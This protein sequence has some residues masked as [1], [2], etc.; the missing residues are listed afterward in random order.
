LA[1]AH[2]FLTLLTKNYKRVFEL[3]EVIIRNIVSFFHPR[4]SKNDIFDDVIITSTLHSKYN[5][6]YISKFRKQILHVFNITYLR[7]NACQNCKI[8]FC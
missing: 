4:Y 6:I 7:D 2:C 5:K 3:V 8:T 1:V